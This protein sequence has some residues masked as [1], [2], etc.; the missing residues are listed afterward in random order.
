MQR[1]LNGILVH[2]LDHSAQQRHGALC[3]F[4]LLARQRA[5]HRQKRAAYLYI[6]QAELCEDI[7]PRHGAGRRN[8]ILLPAGLDKF[9]RP[10]SD[11]LGLHAQLRQNFPQ[12]CHA[13]GQRIQK[14]QLDRRLGDLQRNAGKARTAA[15]ID[16]ALSGKVFRPQKR[17]AVEKMQLGHSLRLGDGREVHDLVF[18]ISACPNAQ[19]VSIC[20]GDKPERASSASLIDLPFG[21]TARRAFPARSGC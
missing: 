4:H 20:S 17:D 19:S 1:V 12:P 15:D 3:F 8:I 6:R 9:F 16:H 11:D 7:Q 2:L 14:R 21:Y 13:L 18:S 5:L 10:G